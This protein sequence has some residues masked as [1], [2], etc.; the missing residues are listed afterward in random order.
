M[1]P[2]ILLIPSLP[3]ICERQKP[4]GMHVAI[5]ARSFPL[6]GCG[7]ARC[8]SRPAPRSVSS[9]LTAMS[10]VFPQFGGVQ[11]WEAGAVAVDG[12]KPFGCRVCHG[13]WCWPG[14][15]AVWTTWCRRPAWC[16]G[17]TVVALAMTATL[18]GHLSA[19][20]GETLSPWDTMA[21]PWESSP[22]LGVM[23]AVLSLYYTWPWAARLGPKFPGKARP[24]HASGPGLGLFFWPGG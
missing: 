9:V 18:S 8:G 21:V 13:L 24:N 19:F 16:G 11:S 17:G 23:V 1:G 22:S 7:G 4:W 3:H 12:G 14:S 10:L 5:L 6:S 2:G 15:S 20:A